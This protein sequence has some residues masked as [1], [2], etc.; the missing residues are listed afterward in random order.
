MEELIKDSN[1]KYC[2]HCASII[3]KEAVICPKC[4]CQVEDFKQDSQPGVIINNN[5]DNSSSNANANTNTNLNL[6]SGGR[7]RHGAMKNKW[8]AFALCFFLGILGAHKFYEEKVGMG[9][10][11]LFTA[12]LFGIG[13][14]IDLITI[15]GKPQYYYPY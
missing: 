12:G 4:G 2:K 5:N 15:L 10:L 11:Y 14:L 13:W 8:V 3:L 1:T 7:Y 6:N 9:V